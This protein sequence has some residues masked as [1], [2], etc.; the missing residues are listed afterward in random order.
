MNKKGWINLFVKNSYDGINTI[1]KSKLRWETKKYKM[2]AVITSILT[3]VVVSLFTFVLGLKSGKNQTDRAELQKLYKKLYLYFLDI[4]N[5]LNNNCLIRW[6]DNERKED[7]TNDDYYYPIVQNME[8]NGDLLQLKNTITEKALQLEEKYI[9]YER[10]LENLYNSIH[11]YL[12]SHQQEF[13]YVGLINRSF[14]NNGTY[15]SRLETPNH[16]KCEEKLQYTYDDLVNKVKLLEL[17]DHIDNLEDKCHLSF[18]TGGNSPVRE[19]II[20]PYSLKVDKDSF[21][22]KISEHAHNTTFNSTVEKE[23]LLKKISILERKLAKRVK[24]P[25]GF[26]ETFAGAFIDIFR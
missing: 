7:G 3:S 10:N 19:F 14:R 13:F 11:E 20:Y 4:E 9:E 17:L 2:N 6:E 12:I 15:I 18:S 23:T 1:N 25:T 16:G 24:E 22:T 21:A 26:W 5:N 8:K